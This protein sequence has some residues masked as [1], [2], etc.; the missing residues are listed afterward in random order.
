MSDA[1]AKTSDVDDDVSNSR[2]RAAVNES[3]IDEDEKQKLENRRAYNRQCAA[4][5]VCVVFESAMCHL[6]V[7]FSPQHANDP[8]NW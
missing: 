4:K 3:Q 2:K 5:G 1:V 7:V 8:K 6:I